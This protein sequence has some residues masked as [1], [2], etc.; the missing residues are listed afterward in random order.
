MWWGNENGRFRRIST[1]T[2]SSDFH[3]FVLGIPPGTTRITAATIVYIHKSRFAN[4]LLTFNCTLGITGGVDLIAS[5]ISLGIEEYITNSE[6]EGKLPT[7]VLTGINLVAHMRQYCCVKYCDRVVPQFR[8]LYWRSGL[9]PHLIERFGR[10]HQGS[11]AD[12]VTLKLVYWST[13]MSFF[14]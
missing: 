4:H 12:G 11:K 2:P 7:R 14:L 9:A 1:T 13:Q 3:N 10:A 5:T 8:N 6:R